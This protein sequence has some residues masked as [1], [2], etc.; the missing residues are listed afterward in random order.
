MSGARDSSM[1]RDTWMR[2]IASRDAQL[3]LHLLDLH[4][5][6]A[7]MI[8]AKLFARRGGLHADFADYMQSATLGLL[9]AMERFD[10]SLG[11][12]FERYA[13]CRIRGAVL[14]TLSRLS[15]VH[16]QVTGH[17]AWQERT[18]SLSNGRLD[19]SAEDGGLNQMADLALELGI[20]ILLLDAGAGCADTEH[21]DLGAYADRE[22][23][24]LAQVFAHLVR[25]LP[26]DEARVV[27]CH[28][29]CGIAFEAIAAMTQ[30]S[31][32][33]VSQLHRKALQ[34]LRTLYRAE[35]GVD[36]SA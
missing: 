36:F 18:A 16:A 26:P 30:V 10:P 29:F 14:D 1:E 6:F 23:R 7:R 3:R 24:E 13:A 22:R 35:N 17:N 33:R 4:L 28:Y 31:R 12:P 15:E 27:R 11:I 25:K 9:E 2:Y 21:V 8:A 34:R 19:A 5:P 32:A 20:G